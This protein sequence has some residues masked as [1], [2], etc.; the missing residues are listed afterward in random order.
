MTDGYKIKFRFEIFHPYESS[1]EFLNLR[2]DY[3]IILIPGPTPIGWAEIELFRNTML[4]FE[5]KVIGVH[6]G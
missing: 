5:R 2:Y 4:P 3:E 6:R 1:D